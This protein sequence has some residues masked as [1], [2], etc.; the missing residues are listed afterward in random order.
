MPLGDGR[1]WVVPSIADLPTDLIRDAAGEWQASPRPQFYAFWMACLAW[2][3]RFEQ[4]REGDKFATHELADFVEEALRLNYRLTTEVIGR[5]R[6]FST[7]ANG[8][9]RAA[10]A[11]A[12]G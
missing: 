12:M 11:A 9:L 1:L 7:G 5:L 6:L 2:R 8:T 3:D 4:A 10:L